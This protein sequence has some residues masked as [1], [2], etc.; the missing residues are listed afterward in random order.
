MHHLRMFVYK[1]LCFSVLLSWS[2]MS[3]CA[4]LTDLY[5]A[6]VDANQ[7]QNQWQQAA[8]AS[9]LV[10]LT[11]GEAILKNPAIA[12]AIRSS[13]D[14]IKQFQMV[15]RDGRNLLQVTL[16][17]QKISSLL[18]Q[19]QIPIWGSRRPDVLLWLTEKTLEA[20][21]LV[22]LAEH[23][24]R[25]ALI[26]QAKTYGLSYLFP[27]Y[28]EQ[29]VALINA[30]ALWSG[31]WSGLTQVS[32]SYQATQV[33]NLLVEQ[34]VDLTGQ[35]QY[36]LTSQTWLDGVLQTQEFTGADINALLLQFSQQLAAA[37][38]AQ[39]AVNVQAGAVTDSVLQLKLEGIESLTDLVSVQKL[40][41]AMLTVRQQQL[42]AFQP[43]Q[44][45]IQLT[46]ASTEPDFYRALA[47]EK[48]LQPQYDV[49]NSMVEGETTSD[50]TNLNEQSTAQ[51]PVA[52]DTMNH[53]IPSQTAPAISDAE[54]ALEAALSSEPDETT[55]L[56]DAA[57]SNV[58]P[59][60]PPAS[61][62]IPLGHAH[63]RFVRP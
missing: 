15:Q 49:K 55:G 12:T 1:A 31:D 37:Q 22:V 63:F 2:S 47:L 52:S 4:E 18:Q 17:Q 57:T 6:E 39:Y 43:G 35:L 53:P 36:R 33:F 21:Q 8:V 38:A 16:D 44:A 56:V 30:A 20:P 25:N 60:T 14:F 13:S 51:Q 50:T 32:S 19:L 62:V 46:L 26:A 42:V 7:S 29:E 3:L 61:V 11:G 5:Q 59:V 48:Q 10:K 28:D 24:L 9:V 40:F 54:Q 34:N 41:T 27:R 58:L 23:P 45:T